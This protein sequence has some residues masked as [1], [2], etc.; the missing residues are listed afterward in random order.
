[1]NCKCCSKEINQLQGRNRTRCNS[2]NTKIRRTRN[3]LRA[4]EL[5]GGKCNRCGFNKYP[6]AMQFHH[7]HDKKFE[8]GM[9]ANK[10]WDSIVEEIKKCE[11][12]CGNCH[13]E[14][15]SERYSEEFMKFVLEYKGKK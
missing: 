10:S 9:V 1:M 6:S 12:I 4:I 8:I 2:C 15:H 7:L 11:L 5:L 3:K 14:E 13:L